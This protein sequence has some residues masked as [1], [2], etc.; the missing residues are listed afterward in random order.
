[1]L[2]LIIVLGLKV[3]AASTQDG[4]KGRPA[5]PQKGEGSLRGEAASLAPQPAKCARC[6]CSGPRGEDARQEGDC[7]LA[8]HLLMVSGV[9]HLR[10][11]SPAGRR[12][13]VR[14]RCRQWC[15]SG[16]L[17][18]RCSS[19]NSVE[20]SCLGRPDISRSP[21]VIQIHATRFD[22]AAVNYGH[23][24]LLSRRKAPAVEQ[25]AVGT[26]RGGSGS[27]VRREADMLKHLFRC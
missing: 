9:N 25:K 7:P 2:G 19:P 26:K 10:N 3:A 18:R 12:Q 13:G 24:D 16:R 17:S 5:K 22:A 21:L 4:P 1:M 14:S 6:V 15:Y 20:R 11:R 23:V 27:V 8:S